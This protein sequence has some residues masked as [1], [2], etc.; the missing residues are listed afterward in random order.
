MKLVVYYGWD[1]EEARCRTVRLHACVSKNEK[2]GD[3]VA[4]EIEMLGTRSTAV[5]LLVLMQRLSIRT[6]QTLHQ[7]W[8]F[9]VLGPTR[10]SDL[11]EKES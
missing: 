3:D 8:L 9:S 2:S 10:Y 1:L 11:E 6:A 4:S 7:Q 5:R